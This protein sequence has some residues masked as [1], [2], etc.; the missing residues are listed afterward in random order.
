MNYMTSILIIYILFEKY[1]KKSISNSNNT[2]TINHM[3]GSSTNTKYILIP[4]ISFILFF[5]VYLSFYYHYL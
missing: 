1:M 5:I 2:S 4:N 3:I